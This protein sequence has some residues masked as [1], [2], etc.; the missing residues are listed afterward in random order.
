MLVDLLPVDGELELQ[1]FPQPVYLGRVHHAA[2]QLR[3][4]VLV[5]LV[6]EV[7]GVAL[8]MVG[9]LGVVHEELLG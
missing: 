3:V 2:R 8:G 7:G 1:L 4:K 9:V 5:N 6:M